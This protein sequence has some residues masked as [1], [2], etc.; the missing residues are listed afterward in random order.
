MSNK[1]TEWCRRVSPHM[2]TWMFWL[3]VFFLL[4]H[5]SG[6]YLSNKVLD[7]KIKDAAL[8]GGI[9]IDKV[10]YNIQKR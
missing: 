5:F 6:Q 2:H 4:G 1:F 8:L 10:P 3:L 7:T 9:V